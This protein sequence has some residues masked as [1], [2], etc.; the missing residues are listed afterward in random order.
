MFIFRPHPRIPRSETIQMVEEKASSVLKKSEFATLCYYLEEY[1]SKRMSFETFI[2]VLFDLL[3]TA[4]KVIAKLASIYL[5]ILA[6][7]EKHMP[8]VNVLN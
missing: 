2:A 7:I 1:C 6:F 8:L 4:D 3:N 5:H